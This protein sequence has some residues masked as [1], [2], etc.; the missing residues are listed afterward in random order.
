MVQIR[1]WSEAG[2]PTRDACRYMYRRTRTYIHIQIGVGLSV[3]LACTD[4]ALFYLYLFGKFVS[5]YI[6]LWII[7]ETIFHE[8][9]FEYCKIYYSVRYRFTTTDIHVGSE[10][11]FLL[12]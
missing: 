4:L 3:M 10:F 11:T 6:E 5:A 12:S 2:R 8:L 1:A 7:H 9:K